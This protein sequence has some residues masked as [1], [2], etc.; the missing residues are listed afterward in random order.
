M[1]FGSHL[2]LYPTY[3]IFL[4]S[5]WGAIEGVIDRNNTK[6]MNNLFPE[7]GRY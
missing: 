7:D 3:F 4:T 5:F 1:S 6:N 2:I